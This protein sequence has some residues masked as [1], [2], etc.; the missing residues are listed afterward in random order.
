MLL[1]LRIKKFAII[2]N[3]ELSFSSG[4]NVLTG[5]TGA[6][7]SI[8]IQAVNLILGDRA[9]SNLIRSGEREAVVE[10]LF[11]LE[12]EPA[13]IEKL[14]NLGI[15]ASDE[16]VIK[17]I[18]SEGKNKVFLN[19]SM[20]TLSMLTE[21]SESLIN[22][23]S[24]HEHQTLL[25]PENH[26]DILDSFGRLD[27]AKIRYRESFSRYNEVRRLL[28]KMARDEGSRAERVDLLSFQLAEI[29]KAGIKPLEDEELKE[30]RNLLSNAEKLATCASFA[31]ETIYSSE[32]SIVERLGE[33]VAKLKEA[34][35]ADPA[36][37]NMAQLL[38]G[39]LFQ[40]EDAALELREYSGTVTSDPLR[41]DAVSER[42]A[43][44]E[45]LKK[46]Y[47]PTLADLIAHGEDISAELESIGGSEGQKE[48]IEAEL[49]LKMEEAQ[50]LA[51]ELSEERK[52]AASRLTVEI[53]DEL[54]DLGLMGATLE[55]NFTPLKDMAECGLEQAEFF[56]STN[57]GE[58]PR[59][60]AKIASGGELSR[61]MLAIKRRILSGVRVPS[62]VF[63][64]VDAGIGGGTAEVVG[65]KLKD[66]SNNSQVICITHLPQIAALGDHHYKVAKSVKEGRTFTSINLLDSN[67]RVE[68]IARMLGGVEITDKTKE[69]AMEMLNKN[70]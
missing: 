58:K 15:D 35:G 57:P 9:T 1:E 45:R 30:E 12:G 43:E 65:R 60:M 16:I 54:Q 56:L 36:M 41:L 3:L 22:I 18:I 55:V 64:E 50:R 6:G 28:E 31:D 21:L 25:K 44:L 23:S 11:S 62:L 27:E 24:Q 26:L 2:D 32:G 40:M 37:G 51:L 7:K 47:G 20:V 10:A 14:D 34:S 63:D 13:L 69:H 4:M 49:A 59:P 70:A 46:K 66:V 38:E 39:L 61:I 68:E 42:L 67:D 29:T 19:G 53:A 5:E 48:Q 8:I 52:A 17:R 33:V